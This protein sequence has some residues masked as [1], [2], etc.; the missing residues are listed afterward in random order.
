MPTVR[1]TWTDRNGGGSQEDEHRIYRSITE[2]D[3]GSLPAV[4]ATVAADVETYDDVTAVSETRYYYAVAAV[5]GSVLAISYLTF[6]IGSPPPLPGAIEYFLAKNSA[7]Q[8]LTV[9]ATTAIQF[10]TEVHDSNEMFAAHRFTV[11]PSMDGFYAILVASVV[12]D[13]SR[14][15]ISYLGIEVSTDGGT[16]WTNV[17]GRNVNAETRAGVTTQVLLALNDI[18]RVVYTNGASSQDASLS[19][20]TQFGGIILEPFA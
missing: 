15:Q 4:L 2:F 9:S 19:D 10:G 8:S 1:L 20:T 7:L 18:Y 13:P 17:A 12:L 14:S 11:Q 5:K 6:E 16:S 3:E